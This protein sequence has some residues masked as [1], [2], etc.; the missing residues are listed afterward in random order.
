MEDNIKKLMDKEYH[1]FTTNSV[2]F[3]EG[4]LSRRKDANEALKVA[5]GKS[6]KGLTEIA[7]V[8]AFYNRM[9]N[10]AIAAFK[11]NPAEFIKELEGGG[12]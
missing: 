7:E 3:I 2:G 1:E 11:G 4:F 12:K 10:A 9:F 8:A 6:H 5:A